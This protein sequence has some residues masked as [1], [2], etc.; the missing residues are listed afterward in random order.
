MMQGRGGFALSRMV[1]TNSSGEFSFP[2]LP[3]GQFTVA[4]YQNQ[5]L[6][7]SY[8]Q[9]RPGGQGTLIQLTDGQQVKLTVP[10]MRGAVITGVVVGPDGEPQRQAQVRG[11][12]FD[13]S[14]GFRRLQS[15]GFAQTDDRGIYRLFGLQPGD[16]VISATP[17]PSDLLNAERMATQSDLVERAIASG[18]VLPPAGPGLPSTVAVPV[19]SPMVQVNVIV[20]PSY[21]ATYAPSEM[22]PSSA[23]T[24]TVGGA[25]ERTGVDIHVQFTLAS[26]VQGVV[27]TPPEPGVTVQLSL[28]SDDATIDAPQTNSTRPDPTGKFSFRTVPPG[29]YTVFAQ[30]VAAPPPVTFVDGQPAQ[31]RPPQPVLTDAQKKWGKVQVTVAGE[32]TID[33]SVSLRPART[34]SGV[35]VFDMVKPP[36]LSRSRFLVTVSRAPAPQQAFF[37]QAPQGQ[38]GPDGRFTLTGVVPGRYILRASGQMKSSMV[39]GQDTLDFPLEFTGEHDVTDAVLTVTD[40]TSE[41][42]GTLTDSGGKPAVDYMIVAASSDSRY[43][44]PGSRRVAMARPG[45]DGRY[46]FR[47]LP[48]GVYH[49]AAVIDPEPGAQFDP[50]FLRTV[51]RGS[52]SV[53]ITEGGKV[54]QDLRVK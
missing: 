35:V 44:T 45:T 42:S 47:S 10:M 23:M 32:P 12:R 36:D 48:P 37:G 3:A 30:T 7:T 41:L 19:P 34:I 18:R 5:F 1:I 38:V 26:T 49:V 46:V 16:Y 2:R 21:L 4:V 17:S 20:P 22:A 24:V 54:S 40:Q 33:V 50:E 6:Q 53:T 14:S 28:F 8:G 29:K 15:A 39:S 31:P 9:R 11:W 51:A 13:T 43:W 27:L 52:W 25:E